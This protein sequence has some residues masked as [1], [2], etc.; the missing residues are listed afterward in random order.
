MANDVERGEPVRALVDQLGADI[1]QHHA[2]EPAHVR[3]G[4]REFFN[5]SRIPPVHEA[6]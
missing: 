2:R 6:Q 4:I 5:V 1:H 3:I